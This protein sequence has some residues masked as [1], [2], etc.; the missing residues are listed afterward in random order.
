MRAAIE[1][2]YAST[3]TINLIAYFFQRGR[4]LHYGQRRSLQAGDKTQKHDSRA[5][6]E[7]ISS[8]LMKNFSESCQP[9]GC[10]LRKL[11]WTPRSENK[12]RPSLRRLGNAFGFS[13]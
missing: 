11:C 7:R 3:Q 8:R 2:G 9:F 12:L 4:G 13:K 1:R 10:A 6:P 5:I